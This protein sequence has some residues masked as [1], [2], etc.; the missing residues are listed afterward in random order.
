[1]YVLNLTIVGFVACYLV[2][3]FI[4]SCCFFKGGFDWQSC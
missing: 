2:S 4:S 3:Y 1:M